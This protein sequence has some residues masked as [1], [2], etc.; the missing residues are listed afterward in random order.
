MTKPG[1]KGNWQQISGLL[2]DI[3]AHKNG[4]VWGLDSN[5]QSF[6]SKGGAGV[7]RKVPKT[8]FVYQFGKAAE[9]N[10]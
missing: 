6:V 9:P 4:N 5:N 3:S 10:I 8:V 2:V 7:W 1:V